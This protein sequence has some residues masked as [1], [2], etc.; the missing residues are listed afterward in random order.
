MRGALFPCLL[1]HIAA[2]PSR[3]PRCSR[4][5]RLTLPPNLPHN[6]L[7]T[8]IVKGV[9]HESPYSLNVKLLGKAAVT[10]QFLGC[11]IP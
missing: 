6:P 10:R 5:H 7:I 11:I 1:R 4:L 9:E 2:L 8:W 3:P